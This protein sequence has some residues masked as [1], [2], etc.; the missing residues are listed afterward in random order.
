M[1]P[2]TPWRR[3]AS[4]AAPV[5]ASLAAGHCLG[6]GQRRHGGGAVA[7]P[8]PRCDAALPRSFVCRS[9]RVLRRHSHSSPASPPPSQSLGHFS[10]GPSAHSKDLHG[11]ESFAATAPPPLR[12]TSHRVCIHPDLD[13]EIMI[14]HVSRPVQDLLT[15]PS[16]SSQ[17]RPRILELRL[18]VTASSLSAS[19]PLAS[20]GPSGFCHARVHLEAASGRASARAPRVQKEILS[21]RDERDS[22]SSEARTHKSESSRRG[23]GDSEETTDQS[24]AGVR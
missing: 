13:A 15:D 16:P 9:L 18:P 10:A 1:L 2:A 8:G 3:L 7:A 21:E 22:C 11:S 5:R 17:I 24:R 23:I 19:R 6:S 20:P 4:P 12:N 14:G